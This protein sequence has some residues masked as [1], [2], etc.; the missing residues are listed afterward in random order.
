MAGL[1][2][3]GRPAAAAAAAHASHPE[4][5]ARDERSKGS[6]PECLGITGS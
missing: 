2:A 6:T 5:V 4:Q 1:V 3:T